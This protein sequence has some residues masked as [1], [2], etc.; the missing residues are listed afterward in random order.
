MSSLESIYFGVPMVGIP[1]FA[2]QFVNV[3]ANV[4]REVAVMVKLEDISE[5]KLTLA[6]KS[7]LFDPK[8]R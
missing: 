5:E 4:K 8:Y 7:V 6:F 1:L 2:D 3:E